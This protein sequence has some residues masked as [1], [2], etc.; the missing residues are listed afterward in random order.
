M[1]FYE[2]VWWG[3]NFYQTYTISGIQAFFFFW[4]KK[5]KFTAIK[6]SWTT[7]RNNSLGTNISNKLATG[8]LS[9]FLKVCLFFLFKS[10]VFCFVL[11]PLK[12]WNTDKFEKWKSLVKVMRSREKRQLWHLT[13]FWSRI[14]EHNFTL[15][16]ASK[17]PGVA[18]TSLQR[19]IENPARVPL[20]LGLSTSRTS[21]YLKLRRW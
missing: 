3:Q 15:R 8:Q 16:E 6:L 20:H 2:P 21:R 10:F 9:F 14:T 5:I 12:L 4:K 11:S 17:K 7:I 18:L 1:H 19:R 13:Q